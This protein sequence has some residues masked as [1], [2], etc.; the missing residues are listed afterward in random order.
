MAGA[1]GKIKERFRGKGREGKHL[2]DQLE[3][4]FVGAKTEVFSRIS[5]KE[6]EIR[7]KVNAER[8]KA[9]RLL[10]DAK[11]EAAAI[12]RKATLEEIGKDTYEQVIAAA[13][14]EVADIEASTAREVDAVKRMGEERLQQAVDYIIGAVV[15][16]AA[17]RK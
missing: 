4:K 10:E 5:A 14:K 3:E 11:G 9:E 15:A 2:S 7:S 16:P 8:T 6:A 13:R 1:K 17:A 12:K